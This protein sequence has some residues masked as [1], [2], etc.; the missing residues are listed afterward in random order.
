[1][2]GCDKPQKTNVVVLKQTQSSL[3]IQNN[4]DTPKKSK[5]FFLEKPKNHQQN[6]LHWQIFDQVIPTKYTHIVKHVIVPQEV[7]QQYVFHLK[8]QHQKQNYP[9]VS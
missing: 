2:Q 7:Q 4:L 5:N 3:P 8:Q 6:A 1:L 9:G